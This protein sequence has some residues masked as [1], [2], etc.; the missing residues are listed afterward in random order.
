[1]NKRSALA[2]AVL[3]LSVAACSE[4]AADGGSEETSTITLQ[5][6]GEPEETRVYRSLI[7]QF[8]KSN[9]RVTV[10][11]VEIAEKSDHLAKLAT[12]FAGANPPELFLVNFREYSQFVVRGAIEPIGDLL[13]ERG[14]DL[15]DFYGPPIE[16]FTYDEALQCMPQNVSSLA[17]Y[18]NTKL[19][20]KAG[21]DPPH[22]GWNWEEFR[23]AAVAL[24]EGEVDGLGIAPEIIRIAP[25]VWSNGG[26]LTDDPEAPTRFTL[27]E[28]AA[29]EALEFIVGLVREDQVVPTEKEVAGQ[30]LETRFINGKLGMFLSSRRETPVFR[31]VTTLKWD[32]LPLPV[33]EQPAGILHSDAYCISAGADAKE[34]AA[35]FVAFAM[36]EEAQTL[37]ALSGRTVPSLKSVAESGAFLDPS[38]PPAHSEVFTD[39]IASLR[40]TPVL[41][42]WPEIEDVAEEILIKAFYE[43]GY[44]IDDTIRELDESTRGLFEEAAAAG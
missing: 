11:L 21:L 30:D 5:V 17:V 15:A 23:D 20:R 14:I 38:Q 39:A 35:D 13:A 36:S 42:T 19:F 43:E 40:Q 12:S 18:Y 8:T 44:T 4:P 34:A 2:C 1:M 22:G 6:S 9:P 24:T 10:K 33:A 27:H 3:V 32:V 37:A 29:R 25:F 31:E 7:E 16:A 28:P 26:E 41:P